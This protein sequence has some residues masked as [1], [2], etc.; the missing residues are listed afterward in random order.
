[1]GMM[2]E[3]FQQILPAPP[4]GAEI[5]APYRLA[6]EFQ[7]EAQHR[8]EIDEYCQWYRVTAE[9][10]QQELRKMQGDINLFGW[11]CPGNR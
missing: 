6:H 5:F 10:H 8:Q 11:F 4:P 9:R 1:M 7:R 2:P 3:E